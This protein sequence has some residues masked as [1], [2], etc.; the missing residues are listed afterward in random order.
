MSKE[1]RTHITFSNYSQY[2]SHVWNNWYSEIGANEK[3]LAIGLL[4]E[5]MFN[6]NGEPLR[7]LTESEFNLSKFLNSSDSSKMGHNK[8]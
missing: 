6:T 5:K 8:K 2:K 7:M 4:K 3:M 1:I